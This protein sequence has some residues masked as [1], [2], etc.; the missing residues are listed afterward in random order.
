MTAD[1]EAGGSPPCFGCE[2]DAAYAGYLTPEELAAALARLLRLA[3]R[4]PDRIRR[5]W[6]AALDPAIAQLPNPSEASGPEVEGDLIEM[7]GKLMP[8]IADDRLHA[9][10]KALLT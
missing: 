4:T 7:A 1:E 2:M 10:I 9:A 6:H 3:D 5:R 8:R